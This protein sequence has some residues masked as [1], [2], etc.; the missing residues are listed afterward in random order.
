MSYIRNYYGVT[1]IV[2]MIC[3]ILSYSLSNFFVTSEN[4]KV[5]EM[6]VGELKYSLTIGSVLTKTITVSPGE[7][8]TN[9]EIESLND[10]TTKYMLLMENN[11]NVDIV[12]YLNTEDTSGNVRTYS[13]TSGSITK[14]SSKEIKVR[15]TNNT[16]TNQTLTFRVVGG[17]DTNTVAQIDIPKGYTVIPK[18]TEKYYFCYTGSLITPGSTYSSGQYEYKYKYSALAPVTAANGVIRWSTTALS[19]DGWGVQATNSTAATDGL[20]G[21]ICSY[22]DDK[23]IVSTAYMYSKRVDQTIK[24]TDFNT[25]NVT[26]MAGMFLSAEARTITIGNLNTSK[27]KSMSSMFASTQVTKLDLSSFDTSNV[28]NMASMFANNTSIKSIYASNKFV[29][30]N[31][32]SSTNMFNNTTSIIGSNDTTYDSTKKDKTYARIDSGSTNPGYLAKVPNFKTDTWNEIKINVKA[33]RYTDY[34]LGDTRTIDLGTLGT[35]TLRIANNTTPENC[36]ISGFSRTGCGLVIEFED[37]ITTN[38]IT[39]SLSSNGGWQSST[40]R[41]Y[42][43]NDI[44]NAMPTDLQNAIIDTRVI[45]GHNENESNN[46]ATLDKIYLLSSAEVWEEYTTMINIIYPDTAYKNSRQ[47]D[48]YSANKVATN[49]YS[50]AIKKKNGTASIWWLRTPSNSNTMSFFSVAASGARTSYYVN[51]SYGISPAFRVGLVSDTISGGGSS[52]GGS[53]I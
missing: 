51:Q 26:N 4:H 22:I 20:V 7:T 5:A 19:E 17:Y 44:Y 35:H 40:M 21:K 33:D 16:T 11:S 27:V 45:S 52:G 8:L 28:T 13:S 49:N 2:I 48:Y 42:V 12:Y 41:T 18:E 50:G 31:V 53:T 10:V 37:I 39:S 24:V 14:G 32:T 9:I 23:P 34:T 47:L 43:N 36:S 6:Y 25:S 1:I 3:A 46:Y 15:I 38:K 29:T 30:T